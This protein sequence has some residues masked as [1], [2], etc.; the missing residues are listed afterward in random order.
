[1][2]TEA[3]APDRPY[4]LSPSVALRPEPFGALVYDFTTRKLSFLKTRLLVDVVHALEKTPDAHAAL[5]SA[6]VPD[7]QH[8]QY[9]DALAG[10]AS[11]GTIEVRGD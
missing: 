3:F 1:M 8:D 4:R 2:S 6:E 9:L 5:R 11:A 10:L 7:G